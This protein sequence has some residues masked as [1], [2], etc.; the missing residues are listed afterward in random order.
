MSRGKEDYAS[1]QL[2]HAAFGSSVAVQFMGSCGLILLPPQEVGYS[3]GLLS[4]KFQLY[5]QLK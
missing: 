3:S 4:L 1:F 5:S 2:S